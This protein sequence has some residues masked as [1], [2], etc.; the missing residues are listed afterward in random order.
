MDEEKQIRKSL[1]ETQAVYNALMHSCFFW[2][3]INFL[4]INFG[5]LPSDK[6]EDCERE[7]KYLLVCSSAEP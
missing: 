2:S 3:F 1:V 7:S 6:R 5:P 4:L